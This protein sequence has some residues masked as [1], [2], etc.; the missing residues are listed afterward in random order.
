[1]LEEKRQREE[2]GETREVERTSTYVLASPIG[3]FFQRVGKFAIAEGHAH[4]IAT[5]GIYMFV[6]CTYC[7]PEW[8]FL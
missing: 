1:M 8:V 3:G 5:F 2:D 4:E 6:S 7:C